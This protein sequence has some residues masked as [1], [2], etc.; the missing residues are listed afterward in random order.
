MFE[1]LNEKLENIVKSIQGRA[2]ISEKDL[3]STMREIRIVLL[4][5]DVALPVVKDFIE[6]V[7]KI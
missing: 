7:K 2:I 5:A 1:T 6:N 4:E 3:D